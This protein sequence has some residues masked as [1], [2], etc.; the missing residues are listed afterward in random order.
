M[1]Q[2]TGLG[3]QPLHGSAYGKSMGERT[4]TTNIVIPERVWRMLRDLAEAKAIERGG[5]PNASAVVADLVSREASRAKSLEGAG[6]SS[7]GKA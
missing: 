2:K 5:R 6:G 3:Y 7:N 4:V 1:P